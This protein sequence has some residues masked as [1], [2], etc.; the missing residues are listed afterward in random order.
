M[1]SFNPLAHH[2]DGIIHIHEVSLLFGTAVAHLLC[3]R[4]HGDGV[5]HIHDVLDTQHGD[6]AIISM[7]PAVN[8]CAQVCTSH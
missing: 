5:I 7:H 3:P 1:S 6:G 4:H 8:R 2:G